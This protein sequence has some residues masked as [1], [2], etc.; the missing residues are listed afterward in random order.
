L[1]EAFLQCA[2]LASLFES[3][4]DLEIELFERGLHVRT[5]AVL[6]HS[7]HTAQR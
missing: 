2:V 3:L 1:S 4:F 7:G 6:H 5:L